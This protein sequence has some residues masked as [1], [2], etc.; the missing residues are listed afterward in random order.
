MSLDPHSTDSP[1]TEQESAVVLAVAEGIPPETIA[2]MDGVDGITEDQISETC[3]RAVSIFRH[4][5][6]LRRNLGTDEHRAAKVLSDH[7]SMWHR[8]ARAARR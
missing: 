8:E 2:E 3:A 7:P 4:P 5:A 1:L 6:A